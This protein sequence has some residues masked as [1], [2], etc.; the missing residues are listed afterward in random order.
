MEKKKSFNQNL[1]HIKD[2]ME[3]SV[4]VGKSFNSFTIN[5]SLRKE[6]NICVVL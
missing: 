5:Y 4:I 1:E 6:Q 2:K 3:K